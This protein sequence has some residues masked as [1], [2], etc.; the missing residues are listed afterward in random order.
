MYNARCV[1]HYNLRELWKTVLRQTKELRTLLPF[2]VTDNYSENTDFVNKEKQPKIRS[3]EPTGF[4]ILA[5]ATG[6]GPATSTVTVWRS[7][8]LSYAP[9]ILESLSSSKIQ[10]P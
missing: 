6:L 2:N 8:Q 7:N 9:P 1:I 3:G 10:S 4:S 5:G